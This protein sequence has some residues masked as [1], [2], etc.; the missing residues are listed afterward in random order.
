MWGLDEYHFFPFVFGASQLVGH[1]V[2]KPDSICNDAVLEANAHDY[3][4]LDAVQFVRKVKKGPL[5]ETSP[6]LYDISG[7]ASWS[8]VQ[9]GL[10]QSW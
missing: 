3:L 5:H 6:M 10:T 8:K 1:P 2:I 7:V 4:Y 9:L